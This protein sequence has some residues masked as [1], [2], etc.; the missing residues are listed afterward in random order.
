[1]PAPANIH[2]DYNRQHFLLQS[3]M[4]FP[5]H[6]SGESE[7]LRIFPRLYREP[8]FDMDATEENLRHLGDPLRS[9]PLR[10]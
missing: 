3:N 5:L 7:M 4:W 2:S 6:D 10:L 1:M 8:I 9:L